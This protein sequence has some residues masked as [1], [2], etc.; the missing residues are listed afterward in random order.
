MAAATTSSP[1]TS[2][3]RPKGLLL[4]TIKLARSEAC[5]VVGA[6]E[7]IDPFGGGGEQDPVPGLAGAD[8]DPGREVGLARAARSEED[9]IVLGGDEIQGA[10]VGDDLAPEAAGMDEVEVLQR[11]AG[12]EAGGADPAFTDMGLAGSDLA[13]R[14]AARNSS[15]VHDASR[16][17]S[18][19][20]GW[21][22]AAR[23]LSTRGSGTP[24]P[25]SRHERW[26]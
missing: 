20:A 2:P 23:G 6:G 12:G 26:S 17:R 5:V 11:F 13:F 25:N 3:H 1:K 24:T 18:P 21:P 14:Q 8:R 15:N 7:P 9:H 16:A 10:E 4:V 19:A 22:P